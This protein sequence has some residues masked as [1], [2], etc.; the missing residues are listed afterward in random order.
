MKDSISYRLHRGR[1]AN[2]K[3][4]TSE[5]SCL[6]IMDN[7]SRSYVTGVISGK[8]SLLSNPASSS[9]GKVDESEPLSMRLGHRWECGRSHHD[10]SL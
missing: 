5:L 3:S 7:N 9:K 8:L 2:L 10:V 4:E 6:L 1:Q